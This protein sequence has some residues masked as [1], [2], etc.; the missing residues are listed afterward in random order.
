MGI[1]QQSPYLLVGY[2]QTLLLTLHT[3]QDSFADASVVFSSATLQLLS[4]PVT[5]TVK[6]A[7][8]EKR[9]I[10]VQVCPHHARA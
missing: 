5:A 2:P 6:S 1:A 3:K 7:N 9:E 10:S 4:S 8:G